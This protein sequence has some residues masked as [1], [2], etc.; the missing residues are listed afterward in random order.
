M[1]MAEHTEWC[2]K[3]SRPADPKLRG[4]VA[5]VGQQNIK[6]SEAACTCGSNGTARLLRKLKERG[7]LR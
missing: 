4:Y 2:A 7:V 6:V 3:T 1:T 5:G